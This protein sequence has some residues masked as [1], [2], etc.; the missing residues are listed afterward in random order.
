M[1]LNIPS[2]K[3]YLIS[4]RSID[5]TNQSEIFGNENI[6]SVIKSVT[7]RWVGHVMQMNDDRVTKKVLLKNVDGTRPRGIPKKR[8]IDGVK[9]DHQELGSV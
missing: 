3:S 5:S 1:L 6:V 7:L 8:W 9:S 2:E 4:Q